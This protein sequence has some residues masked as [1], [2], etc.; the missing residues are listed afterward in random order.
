MFRIETP[1][2]AIAD[3]EELGRYLARYAIRVGG[4]RVQH[5]Q[6]DGKLVDDRPL[7][8]TAAQTAAASAIA[9]PI[10][11][12]A[13]LGLAAAGAAAFVAPWMLVP[14]V[15]NA[16]H[17][18]KQAYEIRKKT[19]GG[20]AKEP[21]GS[22]ISFRLTDVSDRRRAWAEYLLCLYAERHPGWQVMDGL[23]HPEQRASAAR[24]AAAHA[25]YPTPW[26]DRAARG[27]G[28]GRKPAAR[29]P[30]SLARRVWR[31]LWD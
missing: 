30:G 25:G 4:L 1:V 13:G 18:I 2:L 19:P 3:A 24:Y 28:T 7:A 23:R 26:G 10:G 17:G 15:A 16:L 8:D 31:A 9:A 27:Q 12:G 6:R 11:T 5:R 22:V 21:V 20:L 14:A 29:K